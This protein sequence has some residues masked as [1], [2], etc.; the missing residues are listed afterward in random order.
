MSSVLCGFQGLLPI[1]SRLAHATLP[2]EVASPRGCSPFCLSLSMSLSG[3]NITTW[4][5]L[6]CWH[7][8]HPRADLRQRPCFDVFDVRA[9][10]ICRPSRPPDGL[11]I[12]YQT[13]GRAT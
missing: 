2:S 9:H 5:F 4:G 1:S 13:A 6:E 10:F 7:A 11:A 12:G 3:Q 8:S